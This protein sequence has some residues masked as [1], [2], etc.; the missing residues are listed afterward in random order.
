M[1]KYRMHPFAGL[2]ILPKIMNAAGNSGCSLRVRT[3]TNL[4]AL[5]HFGGPNYVANNDALPTQLTPPLS[6]A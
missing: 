1:T 2:I 4:P 5:R 6:V 3:L